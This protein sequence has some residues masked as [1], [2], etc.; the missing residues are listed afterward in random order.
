MNLDEL[1]LEVYNDLKVNN[2]HLDTESLKNQEIKAKYLDIKSKYELLLFKAKGDYKRIYRDK[3][4]YYGGKADAKVYV[5]KPFD[6]KVLKTDLSVYITSDEDII[7]A[8]NKIG[9]LETVVDY[10]K[11]VIKSVDNRGWDIKNA[12][13][14]K[15]FEAGVTY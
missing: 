9:Y 4:E 12:I 6:I 2:E 14:W 7:N 1:K 15:K 10:I 3:W 8:E 11:G 5:S 13:E